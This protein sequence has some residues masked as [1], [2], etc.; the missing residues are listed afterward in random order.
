MPNPKLKVVE[1]KTNELVPYA[2]NAKEHPEWHVGQ[3]VQSI[4]EFGFNDPIGV[5]HDEDGNAVIVE[6]H[7]RLLAA[8]EL[9]MDKVPVVSLDHLDDEGRRAYTLVHNQT[10][11]STG[12]NMELLTAELTALS[13]FDWSDFGITTKEQY[14]AKNE[15]NTSKELDL[16]D[17]EVEKFD[18]ICPRCGMRFNR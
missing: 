13:E 10:N 9:G 14:K 11:M 7:G 8:K 3:I 1:V 5:W 12:F 15:K 4:K 16:S 17:F 18:C 2:G 6:G